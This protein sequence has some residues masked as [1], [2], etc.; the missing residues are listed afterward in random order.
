MFANKAAK[1]VSHELTAIVPSEN[2]R[3]GPHLVLFSQHRRAGMRSL[4]AYHT[5]VHNETRG[6]IQKGY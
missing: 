5:M 2:A 3:R 4:I 1:G 6:I